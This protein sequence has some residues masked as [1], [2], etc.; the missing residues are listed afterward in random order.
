MKNETKNLKAYISIDEE[1]CKGCGLCIDCCPNKLIAIS[2]EKI[3]LKGYFPAVFS[4]DDNVCSGCKL[5][6][7]MCPDVAIT[8]NKLKKAK[9]EQEKTD[10][11]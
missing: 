10:E 3:N 5:C 7:V 11:K 2:N 9:I 8:V 1:L 4:D 6:A